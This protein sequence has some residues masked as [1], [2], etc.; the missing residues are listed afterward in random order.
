M[1]WK[2]IMARLLS[3][4]AALICVFSLASLPANGAE[5]SIDEANR[6]LRV[7]GTGEL[8]ESTS[9]E[10]A[11]EIIRTYS[12][13]VASS[14]DLSLPRRVRDAIAECYSRNYAWENF[15]EGIARI[16]AS[17]LSEKELR[18][19]IGVYQNRGVPPME[20]ETFRQTVRKSDAIAAASAEYIFNNSTGCV[21]QD[22][23]LIKR[24]LAE[25]QL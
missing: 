11:R 12:L 1:F 14:A 6:L 16:L 15:A 4:G 7:T 22:A 21:D 23:R 17:H 8:F 19:L 9:R 20:I 2:P 5:E 10:Q 18:L 24:F 25:K 3:D 13:I